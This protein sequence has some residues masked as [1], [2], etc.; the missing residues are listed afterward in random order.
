MDFNVM[1]STASSVGAVNSIMNWTPMIGLIVLCAI[2]VFL[3]GIAYDYRW[4]K[5]INRFLRRFSVFSDNFYDALKGGSMIVVGYVIYWSG[6][7]VGGAVS[8]AN[9]N[10]FELAG[11]LILAI[12]VYFA[13]AYIGKAGTIVYRKIL[14]NY[15]KSKEKVKRHG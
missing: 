15:N 8:E 6:T 11:W 14:A 10:W 2:S 5:S 1:N 12:V 3:L 7:S 13:L 4:F 9:I